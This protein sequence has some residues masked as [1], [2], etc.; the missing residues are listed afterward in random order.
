MSSG[1]CSPCRTGPGSQ[2]GIVK[3]QWFRRLQCR[4]RYRK[5]GILV[6]WYQFNFLAGGI[7]TLLAGLFVF[8]HGGPKRTTQN[9]WFLLC[10]FTSLWHFGRFF[11]G[12]S[13]SSAVAE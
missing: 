13:D 7:F 5:G 2:D 3:F 6:G 4:V 1:L 9:T 8:Y 11:V 10:L 12:I